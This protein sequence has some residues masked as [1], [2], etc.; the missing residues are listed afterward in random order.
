MSQVNLAIQFWADIR[1]SYSDEWKKIKLSFE[2]LQQEGPMTPAEHTAYLS[3]LIRDIEAATGPDRALDERIALAMGWRYDSAYGWLAPN[4]IDFCPLPHFT[5]SLDAARG[6]IGSVSEWHLSR[7]RIGDAAHRC[8]IDPGL[9]RP[10]ANG[11][12][13][14]E[15]LA[16]LAAAMRMKEQEG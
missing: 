6:A 2:S 10:P 4:E 12:G 16:M 9:N 13:A 11:Y 3:A 5:G 1:K 8:H 14:A 15:P 7:N